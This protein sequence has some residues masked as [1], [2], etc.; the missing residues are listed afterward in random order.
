MTSIAIVGAGAVGTFLA[1]VLAE[2]DHDLVLCGRRTVREVSVSE[3]GADGWHV[4]VTCCDNPVQLEIRDWVFVATKAQHTMTTRRWLSRLVGPATT[5]VA[6]QN[7]ID[8]R[9]RFT[10]LVAEDQVVPALAYFSVERLSPGR[11]VHHSGR[12]LAIPLDGPAAALTALFASARLRVRA[13]GDFITAAWRKLLLNIATG[14]ITAVTGRRLEVFADPAI[15]RLGRGLIDEAAVVGAACGA[16]LTSADRD[17]AIQMCATLPPSG[18]TSM[19]YD[20]L[21]RRELE[22]DYLNGAV[23]RLA[24]QHGIPVPLNHAM[25]A[26][27]ANLGKEER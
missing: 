2:R 8:H 19:L 24:G 3:P 15:R 21:A 26:L 4:G 10:G 1:A 12:D 9:A 13:E 25:V 16:R 22:V 14:P 18:G 17:H 27:L 7:G 20:R 11:L 6:V 23:I 5:V